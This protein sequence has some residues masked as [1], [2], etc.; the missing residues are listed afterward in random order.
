MSPNIE[1]YIIYYNN[2]VYYLLQETTSGIIPSLAAL[3]D[4]PSLKHEENGYEV[5]QEKMYPNNI[6]VL[7]DICCPPHLGMKT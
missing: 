6:Q 2:L 4:V 3:D 5:S 1:S 7:V